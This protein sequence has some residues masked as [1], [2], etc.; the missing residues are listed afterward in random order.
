MCKGEEKRR[1][2]EAGGSELEEDGGKGLD[3]HRPSTTRDCQ[4]ERRKER[5]SWVI[6]TNAMRICL[7]MYSAHPGT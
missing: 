5:D 3:P 7:G 1:E 6:E 4:Q 2:E